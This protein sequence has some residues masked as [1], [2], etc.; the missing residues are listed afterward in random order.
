MIIH[1]QHTDCLLSTATFV[2]VQLVFSAAFLI[3]FLGNQACLNMKFDIFLNNF[4][5][6]I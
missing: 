6:F 4:A 5:Q 3:K 2:K 1:W